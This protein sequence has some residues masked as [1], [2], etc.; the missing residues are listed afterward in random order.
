MNLFKNILNTDKIGILSGP[1]FAIDLAN[2]N[3]VG[4]VVATKYKEIF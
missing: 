2:N 4:F 3:P 1:T